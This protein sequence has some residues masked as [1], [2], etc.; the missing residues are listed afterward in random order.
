MTTEMAMIHATMVDSFINLT[1]KKERSALIYMFRS[2][3]ILALG[4]WLVTIVCVVI[5]YIPRKFNGINS[6]NL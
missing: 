2:N 5:F 1:I 4:R 6:W 3:Q